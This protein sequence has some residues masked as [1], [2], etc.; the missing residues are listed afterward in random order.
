MILATLLRDLEGEGLSSSQ[1]GLAALALLLATFG[2][3]T[4]SALLIY[5]PTKLARDESGSRLEEHLDA[6]SS[7]YQVVARLLMIGGVAAAALLAWHAAPGYHLV[8]SI[9]VLV[10]ALPSVGVVPALFAE[11]RAERVLRVTIPVLRPLRSALRHLLVLPTL[12]AAGVVL[13]ALRVPDANRTA[14]PEEIA[15]EILAAVTDSAQESALPAEERQWIENIVELKNR[16]AIEVITPRTDM[17]AFPASMPLDEAVRQATESGFSR[18]P[19]Y[20]E[21]IDDMIGV[22][23][24]K[25]ALALAAS[26][27]TLGTRRVGD[28]VRKPLFVPESIDLVELLRQFRA[29]KRQMAIVLDE[30]GGTAGVVTIED[31]LE[32]IVGDIEDEYD[33]VVEQPIKVVEEGRV[34]EVSGRT[35]VDEANVHLDDR[36]P[37]G[38]DYDTV[39]GWVFTSLDRIPTTDEELVVEGI[40]I[41][42][43]EADDR[44]IARMRLTLLQVPAQETAAESRESAHDGV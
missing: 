3:V 37:E 42:I 33:P 41:H 20:R 43:L 13:R 24:A 6:F 26:P 32:E 16:Q 35:R 11:A 25:D 38:D 19:V 9:A 5:S 23:Y 30:Y 15:D 44:R 21:R 28:V 22:F 29:T 14:E 4:A 18:D 1:L 8:A 34:I 2:A 31:V 27:E 40:A 12:A 17:V 36:I 7:E 39:A 10:L